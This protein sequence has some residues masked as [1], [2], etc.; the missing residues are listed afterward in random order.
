MYIQWM[1]RVEYICVG[2]Y[3]CVYVNK[4][5]AMIIDKEFNV[6]QNKSCRFILCQREIKKKEWK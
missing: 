2:R 6:C 5:D 4:Y 3:V 1:G